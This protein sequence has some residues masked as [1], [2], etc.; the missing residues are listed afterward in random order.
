LHAKDK[1]KREKLSKKVTSFFIKRNCG[2]MVASCEFQVASGKPSAFG[3]QF[4][5]LHAG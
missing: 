2:Y 3:F 1:E 5:G 4:A